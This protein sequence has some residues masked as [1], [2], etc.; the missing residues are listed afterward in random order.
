MARDSMR[1]VVLLETEYGK[2][3]IFLFPIGERPA[4][5][6]DVVQQSR[7]LSISSKGPLLSLVARSS[8]LEQMKWLK[9]AQ[10]FQSLF[11]FF[12]VNLSKLATETFSLI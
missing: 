8:Q 1:S 10:K 9:C 11:L 7:L 5:V 6:S 12:P 3:D 2:F 4:K